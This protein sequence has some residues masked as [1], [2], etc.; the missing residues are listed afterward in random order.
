MQINRG[1][2]LAITTLMVIFLLLVAPFGF[3][4]P[5]NAVIIGTVKDS[6]GKLVSFA[7][8]NLVFDTD[9]TDNKNTTCNTEGVYHLAV[10]KKGKY[11][12]TVSAIG[13]ISST[14]IAVNIDAAKTYEQHILLAKEGKALQDVKV[15]ARKPPIQFK[16][17]RT[18]LNVAASINAT[19]YNVFELLAKAPGVRILNGDDILLNGKRGLAVYLDGKLLQLQGRELIDFLQTLSSANIEQIEIITHPSARYDAAGNAGIINI[20]TKKNANLG[21]NGSATLTGMATYYKPKIDGSV[22]A[23]Y[24][25]KKYNLYGSINYSGGSYRQTTEDTR[26]LLTKDTGNTLYSQHYMSTFSR[27]TQRYRAG[28][29]FLSFYKKYSK[30]Y[31]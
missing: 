23:N 18:I 17:D 16:A 4:Q 3:S 11:W 31:C 6:N 1:Y 8:I 13:Y 20:R 26:S 29:D 5:F 7:S 21:F 10:A 24:R 27:K 19:G 25:Q 22:N 14:T 28:A 12:L 2:R 9:S 30:F 15:V